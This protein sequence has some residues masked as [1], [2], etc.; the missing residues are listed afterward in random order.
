MKNN[1]AFVTEI[2]KMIYKPA[3][4]PDVRDD[5][6]LINMKVCGIA[7]RMFIFMNTASRSSPMSIPSSS[8]TKV[9][10]KL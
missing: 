1:A 4:M 9:R 7:G 5:D 10:D 2:R 3:P 6:V 8:D